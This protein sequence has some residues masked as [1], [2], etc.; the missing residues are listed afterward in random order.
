MALLDRVAPV[1]SGH[2]TS[3]TAVGD[4]MLTVGDMKP[5][6]GKMEDVHSCT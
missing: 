2:K 6:K 3:I 4:C 5:S 1:E